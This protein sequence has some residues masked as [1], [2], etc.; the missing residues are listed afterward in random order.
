MNCTRLET[1]RRRDMGFCHKGRSAPVA[2]FGR[3]DSSQSSPLFARATRH[4]LFRLLKLVLLLS[5][6]FASQFNFVFD[7]SVTVLFTWSESTRRPMDLK[8]RYRHS[9][10]VG[11][12]L[13][14]QLLELHCFDGFCFNTTVLKSPTAVDRL[15]ENASH[16]MRVAAGRTFLVE[17]SFLCSLCIRTMK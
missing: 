2:L 12:F 10:L 4:V 9:L 13:Y 11:S 1:N 16:N 7:A 5:A 17:G 6:V 3:T 14:C 15:V 8:V